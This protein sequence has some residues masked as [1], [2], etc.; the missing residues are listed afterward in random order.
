MDTTKPNGMNGVCNS[1]CVLRV[2]ERKNKLTGQKL[3][4]RAKLTCSYTGTFG[5]KLHCSNP[6]D[7]GYLQRMW[8]AWILWNPSSTLSKK[9]LRAQCSNISKR[10]LLSQMNIECSSSAVHKI[11][12]GVV[13][14]ST[15]NINSGIQTPQ[16]EQFNKRPWKRKHEQ[17]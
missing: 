12:K 14:P 13:S 8:D 4:A 5:P 15:P 17:N 3:W 11:I 1:I 9:Q 7:R 16:T 10:E 2:W 6:S